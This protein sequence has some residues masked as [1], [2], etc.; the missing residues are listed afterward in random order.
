MPTEQADPFAIYKIARRIFNRA[1][2]EVIEER[3]GQRVALRNY[4]VG[5]GGLRGCSG[6]TVGYVLLVDPVDAMPKHAT[7]LTEQVAPVFNRLTRE[8][9]STMATESE[10][11]MDGLIGLV[12]TSRN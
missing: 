12:G 2:K 1:V 7:V 5:Y 11:W 3:E 9:F 8:Y 10:K 4:G 6:Y